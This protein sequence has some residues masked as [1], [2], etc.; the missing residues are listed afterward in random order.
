MNF[1]SSFDDSVIKG[2]DDG[3]E[4]DTCF[5]TVKENYNLVKSFLKVHGI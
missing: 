3:S 1:S 2:K 4:E 5:K